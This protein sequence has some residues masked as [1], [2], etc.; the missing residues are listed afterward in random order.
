M[1]CNVNKSDVGHTRA[2]QK[3]KKGTEA[4]FTDLSRFAGEGRKMLE[5]RGQ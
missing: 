1:T 4:S 3:Q 5:I 2:E